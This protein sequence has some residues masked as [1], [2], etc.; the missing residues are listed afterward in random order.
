L[1][2]N[3]VL[4]KG[5]RLLLK[6]YLDSSPWIKINL[7][8]WDTVLKPEFLTK[9]PKNTF[10]FE[11]Q[12]VT[13]S[14]Y[15]VKSGRVMLKVYSNE[16]DEKIIMFAEKG[17]IFG[18]LCLCDY[19]L[20]PYSAITIV[21]CE[22]YKIPANFFEEKLQKDPIFNETYIEI[23]MRKTKV[24]ISQLTGLSFGDTYQRVA[25]VMLYLIGIYG[26]ELEN[27]RGILIDLNFTHQDL[28]DL[29]NS[30]RVTI[31]KVIHRMISSGII[32][33]EKKRYVIKNRERLEEIFLSMN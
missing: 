6:R 20:Q 21:D 27:D 31:S 28:A 3:T 7:E 18:E 24:L 33:K 9:I 4:C 10:I 17:G 12:E 5:G 13:N 15:I 23:L 8:V 14:I 2:S 1:E 22:I 32:Q 19:G 26:V 16:G 30:T 11:Q 29:V 25:G